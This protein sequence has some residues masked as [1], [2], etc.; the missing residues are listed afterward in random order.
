VLSYQRLKEHPQALRAFTGLDQAEFE[1]LLTHFTMAY[2][3]YVYDQH[4]RKKSRKRRYGG[5]RKSRLASMED[6]LLFILFYFKVYPLQEVLAFLFETSQG[7]VNEW[8]HQ[9][10]TI[11]KMALGKAQVL[12]ER[13]PKNLEQTLALC[14]AVDFIIDGT[15]RRIQRPKDATAQQEKYSGKKKDHTVKNNLIIDIEERLVRYLSQTFAGRIHDKRIC[16]EEDYTFP[17]GCVLFKDTGFQ[18]FEPE[19]VLTYQP[20]K[21]PR[22]QELSAAE[23]AENQ[24]ISSIRI[25]IEHVISGVKRCRIVHE[26]FRNTKAQFDDLVMEIACGLHNFRTTLRYNAVE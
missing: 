24:M 10:S 1:K 9:L 12:P 8:I 23:K 14:V 18:G 5:G 16:D 17:P 4:V 20:K 21:K 3:A 25:L 11:L 19:N 7:R 22:N 13:D 26:V 6:K 15:E 2:H